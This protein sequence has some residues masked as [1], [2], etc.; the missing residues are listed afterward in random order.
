MKYRAT[1]TIQLAYIGCQK[2]NVSPWHC[3]V[4][5]RGFSFW[6]CPHTTSVTVFIINQ[7]YWSLWRFDF[8]PTFQ[9][10][11]NLVQWWVILSA[12]EEEDNRDQTWD[13]WQGKQMEIIHFVYI[14]LV[15]HI[16]SLV[17]TAGWSMSQYIPNLNFYTTDVTPCETG[18]VHGLT[19]RAYC[20]CS[21]IM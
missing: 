4:I 11:E 6:K 13:W 19:G 8:T 9:W 5:F 3:W 18:R 1:L 16:R 10:P 7:L 20:P 2:V 12:V 17:A 21:W 15:V 14:R